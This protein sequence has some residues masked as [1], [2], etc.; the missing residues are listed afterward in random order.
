MN[1]GQLKALLAV[2][3]E[4]LEILVSDGESGDLEA[5]E[6]ETEL[7]RASPTSLGGDYLGRYAQYFDFDIELNHDL[8]FQWVVV[9]K[10]AR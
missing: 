10:G 7:C 4:D 2:I 1:V 9:F 5:L 3:P 6:V 8:D